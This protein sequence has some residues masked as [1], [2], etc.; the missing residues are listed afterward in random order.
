VTGGL[1]V[2]LPPQTIIFEPVHTA[3]W[4][5]RGLG[6]PVEGVGAQAVH[7]GIW[8]CVTSLLAAS[9]ASFV[10]GL[11]SSMVCP[12][13]G[14]AGALLDVLE[15][16]APTSDAARSAASLGSRRFGVAWGVIE[17]DAS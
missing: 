3:V 5:S 15:Q 8:V 9:Q 16:E 12:A 17:S 6:A 14:P 7:P 11:P 13:Q 4:D 1:P 10:H 2:T